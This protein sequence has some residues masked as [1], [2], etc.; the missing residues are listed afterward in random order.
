[1]KYRNSKGKERRGWEIKRNDERERERRD[2]ERGERERSINKNV[3]KG[4]VEVG[5]ITR[6]ERERGRGVG[7]C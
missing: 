1:M 7:V 4:I 6:K 2:S 3:E 5:S